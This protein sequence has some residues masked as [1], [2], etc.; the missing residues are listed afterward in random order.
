M[1]ITDTSDQPITYLYFLLTES[2]DGPVVVVRAPGGPG[3]YL[4]ADDD[5]LLRILGRRAG[6][7]DAFVDL[8]SSPLSLSWADPADVE[9]KAHAN[10]TAGAEYKTVRVRSTHNP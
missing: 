6:S 1:S 7:A 3:R 2:S 8:F 5:S 4:K 9:V 10:A